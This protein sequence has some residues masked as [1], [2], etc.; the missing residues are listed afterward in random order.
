MTV[1]SPLI[2]FIVTHHSA[3]INIDLVRELWMIPDRLIASSDSAKIGD[4]DAFYLETPSP[5]Y[6]SKLFVWDKQFHAI[7]GYER[8][9]DGRSDTPRYHATATP[10]G[11]AYNPQENK[12]LCTPQDTFLLQPGE[13][14]NYP[15]G[16]PLDTTIGIFVANALFLVY[17]FGDVIDYIN[18]TL[19][20]GKLEKPIAAAHLDG[21]ITVEQIKDRYVNVM[22]LFGQATEII[23]PGISEKTI[24]IPPSINVL[25]E[26]LVKENT[27]ALEA[28]DA[29][30]MSDIEQQLIKAYKDYLQGDPS[31]HFLLKAKYFNVA[32]KKLLLTHGLVEVF[33]S[34][35][36]FTFVDNPMGQGWKQ[37]DLPTIFNEVRAGSYARAIE[38][39]D[40]GVVAKLILRVLQDTRIAEDD[41]GTSRGE[42]IHATREILQDFTWNYLVDKRGGSDEVITPNNLTSFIGQDLIVRTPGF[43]QATKGF[44]AKCFGQL[45]EKVGQKAFAPVANDMA[46][47]FTTMS[48]KSMHGKSHTTVDISNINRYLMA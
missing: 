44:C 39:A 23:C 34:P 13:L 26:R 21:K 18:D 37:D 19:T 27:A 17:P 4:Q 12:P 1:R 20:T 32:L 11:I 10:T 47:N 30:V 42:H 7:T 38:T 6:I 48:L 9:D 36:K 15:T 24:T 5:L 2:N 45:F 14:D 35:G 31:L 33:G 3:L 29:S 25:R 41:C 22:S 28:G 43:C 40:G 8:V 16:T 46:R